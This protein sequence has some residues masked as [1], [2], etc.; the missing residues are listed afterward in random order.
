[1]PDNA[2]AMTAIRPIQGVT[3]GNR[4]GRLHATCTP[5]RVGRGAAP[6]AILSARTEDYAMLPRLTRRRPG[7]RHCRT[8]RGAVPD[9]GASPGHA[10]DHGASRPRG[11]CKVRC[12]GA[13]DASRPERPGSDGRPRPRPVRA[14]SDAGALR[15]GLCH[16][17]GLPPPGAAATTINTAPGGSAETFISPGCYPG[18]RRPPRPSCGRE[19]R[20]TECGA[21]ATR[22]GR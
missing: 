6:G 1:M 13:G 12:A 17:R 2:E 8:G 16:H 21:L 20:A 3:G 5:A 19:A 7:H 10:G 9:A 18:R 11:P 4:D 14:R 15:P 22:C